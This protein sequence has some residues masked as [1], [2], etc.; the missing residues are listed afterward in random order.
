M[1]D[2]VEMETDVGREEA[3]VAGLAGDLAVRGVFPGVVGDR[4]DGEHRI[5]AAVGGMDTGI[6]DEYIRHVVELA[7]LIDHGGLGGT[8]A[9][10]SA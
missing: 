2:V 4:H 6:H 7:V 9:G 3:A 10:E 8:F 1:A 5:E